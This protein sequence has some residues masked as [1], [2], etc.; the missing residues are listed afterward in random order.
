M[1]F[2]RQTL[3][4]N[5]Q[6]VTADA[7]STNT[8]DLGPIK[9]KRRIGHGTPIPLV[10]QVVETFNKATSLEVKLQESDVADFASGVVELATTGA[11]A[12]ASLTAGY[13]FSLDKVPRN[14]SKRYLRLYYDVTG[15]APDAGKITAGVV[16]GDNSNG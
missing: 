3:L 16:L 5:A 9:H 12:L 4:S 11:V 10:I 6:A 2:D 15:T 8:I 14:A 13:R 1:I 7:A